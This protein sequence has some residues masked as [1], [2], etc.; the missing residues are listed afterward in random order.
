MRVAFFMRTIAQY[1]ACRTDLQWNYPQN[2]LDQIVISFKEE[3]EAA[4]SINVQL[5][6]ATAFLD[7]L[8][9]S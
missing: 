4:L 9:Q 2:P 6:A 5:P 7:R 3:V 1:P 8:V